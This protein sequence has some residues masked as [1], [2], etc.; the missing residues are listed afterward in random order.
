MPKPDADPHGGIDFDELNNPNVCVP[1]SDAELSTE[2]SY[3]KD[4]MN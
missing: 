4:E 2:T 1:G 3:F